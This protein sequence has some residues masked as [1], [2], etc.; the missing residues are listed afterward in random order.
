[1]SERSVEEGRDSLP[2][3]TCCRYLRVEYQRNRKEWW[4]VCKHPKASKRR[5]EF[6]E[7]GFPYPRHCPLSERRWI[8]CPECKEKLMQDGEPW[9]WEDEEGRLRG[10]LP[11]YCGGCRAAM[12]VRFTVQVDEVV[13]S[14]GSISESGV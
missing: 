6:S 14:E 9:W 10:V 3:C 5:I 2:R 8:R 13:K 4:E 1:M 7:Y 12:E 11:A